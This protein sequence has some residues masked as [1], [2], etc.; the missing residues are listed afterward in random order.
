MGSGADGRT[1][2]WAG[3]RLSGAWAGGRTGGRS[4]DHRA[5]GG[6]VGRLDRRLVGRSVCPHALG[7]MLSAFPERH[8]KAQFNRNMQDSCCQH[9]NMD[10]SSNISG[11]IVCRSAGL[12]LVKL[13]EAGF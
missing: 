12:I 10:W 4:G 11:C 9:M 13:A 8:D 3:D 5:L 2:G 6:S 7:H 1:G